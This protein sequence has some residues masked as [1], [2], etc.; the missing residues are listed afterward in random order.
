MEQMIHTTLCEADFSLMRFSQ[1]GALYRL[2]QFDHAGLHQIE[3]NEAELRLMLAAL[4]PRLLHDALEESRPHAFFPHN[5][6]NPFFH[7][8]EQ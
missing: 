4:P 5:D 3:L 2:Q 1:G 7:L 8:G 6:N